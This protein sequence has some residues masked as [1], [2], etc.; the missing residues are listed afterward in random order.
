MDIC[1]VFSYI[2]CNVVRTNMGII[3]GDINQDDFQTGLILSAFFYGYICT[4]IP[5]IEVTKV[6]V[7]LLVVTHQLPSTDTKIFPKSLSNA[8]CQT[9]FPSS[10]SSIGSFLTRRIGVKSVLL[11]GMMVWTIFDMSTVPASSNFYALI[12]VRIGVGFGQV[13]LR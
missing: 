2:C 4:Q 7:K 3:V 10:I 8:H 5:G 12:F 1:F 11:I 6:F 9:F 13:F